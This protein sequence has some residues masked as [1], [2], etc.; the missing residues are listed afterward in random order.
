MRHLSRFGERWD[1]VVVDGM[2]RL[3]CVERIDDYVG[4]GGL[5]IVDDTDLLP[6]REV[7]SDKGFAAI[8]FWGFKPGIGLDSCTTAFCRDFTGLLSP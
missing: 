5:V 6:A 7:L 4:E 8:D 1:V 3:S 2:G